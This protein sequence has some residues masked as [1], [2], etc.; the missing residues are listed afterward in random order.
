M[1]LTSPLTF[2]DEKTWLALSA[3]LESLDCESLL[4]LLTRSVL[5]GNTV[6]AVVLK[7]RAALVL[8]VHPARIAPPFNS[9]LED[10][11]NFIQCLHRFALA[12]LLF[13]AGRFSARKVIPSVQILE[14]LV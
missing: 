10:N 14:S 7:N 11:D 13:S 5:A 1:A 2:V 12:G 8:H 6:I 4:N 9:A 3:I